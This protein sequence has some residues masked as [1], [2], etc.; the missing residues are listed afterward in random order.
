MRLQ[1][2]LCLAAAVPVAAQETPTEREAA[3]DIL[4]KMAV[5]EQAVDAPTFVNRLTAANPARDA[6]VSRAM[7]LM[8][9]DLIALGDDITKNPEV[10]F[11]EVKSVK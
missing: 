4:R 2:L 11:T 9:N 3:R 5:L 10:G 1:L 6:V 7:A 8:E